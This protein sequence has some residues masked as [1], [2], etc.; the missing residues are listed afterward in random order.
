MTVEKY[1]QLDHINN[2][3]A[4]HRKILSKKTGRGGTS[5]YTWA[6]RNGFPDILQLLC[7]NCHQAKTTSGGCQPGDH[8]AMRNCMNREQ[9]AAEYIKQS[10]KKTHTSD[11]A[12]SRAPAEEPGPCDCDASDASDG[13]L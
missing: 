9:Q 2:D 8:E 11:C 12:T 13:T 3:G 7:A 5:L 4:A 1:L 6:Y 10:G